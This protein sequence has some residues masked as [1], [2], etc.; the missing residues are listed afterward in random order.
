VLL[1]IAPPG[2]VQR[3]LQDFRGVSGKGPGGLPAAPQLPHGRPPRRASVR[4]RSR[5][6]PARISTYRR[7]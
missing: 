7:L 5:S 3:I 2:L 4:G 1:E 6:A